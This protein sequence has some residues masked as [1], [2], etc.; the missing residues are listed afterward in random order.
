MYDYK[1]PIELSMDFKGLKLFA[2]I[3]HQGHRNGGHYAL[4]VRRYDK[5]YVKDD[6]SVN[7]IP[8]IETMKGEFYMAFYRPTNSL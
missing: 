4:L 8:N 3:L 7:E 5:W 2:C 1:F 6:A